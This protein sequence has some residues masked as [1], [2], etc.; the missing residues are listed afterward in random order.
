MYAHSQTPF[1]GTPSRESREKLTLPPLHRMYQSDGSEAS[2]HYPSAPYPFSSSPPP[3]SAMPSKAPA[4]MKAAPQSMPDER[5]IYYVDKQGH[6]TSPRRHKVDNY[7]PWF[8]RQ[9]ADLEMT[10]PQ[11][12]P[13]Q[14]ASADK[15]DASVDKLP[16]KRGRPPI[17]KLAITEE[18]PA[19]KKSKKTT[20]KQTTKKSDPI[21]AG[22]GKGSKGGKNAREPGGSDNEIQQLD[23][24]EARLAAITSTREFWTE[25][26]KL[27]IV[28]YIVAPE[29]WSNFKLNQARIFQEISM[30][31][32]KDRSAEKV[33]RQWQRLWD[34]YKA[35]RRHAHHTGGGDGDKNNESG[36]DEDDVKP[37]VKGEGAVKARK[38]KTCAQFSDA[39]LDVFE[40]SEIYTLID[41]VAHNQ[42]DVV[43]NFGLSSHRG[44]NDD[45]DNDGKMPPPPGRDPAMALLEETVKDLKHRQSEKVILEERRIALEEKR[46]EIQKKEADQKEQTYV[47]SLW[48]KY[49]ELLKSEDPLA[50]RLANKLGEKLAA[51]E[52]I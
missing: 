3:H 2:Y 25:E 44:D 20:K 40:A 28:S 46:L 18:Q 37:E 6:H 39:Q 51:I 11:Q 36:T 5:P 49:T 38:S 29:R 17:A 35:C 23:P 12:A 10:P 14:E 52:G 22:G 26:D 30:S 21:T 32:A 4:Y 9:Y 1:N 31:V 41:N 27:K 45:S 48:E 33:R 15:Q 24:E 19:A 43:P 8:A 16:A 50:K 7:D 13:Q 42:A 47:L 34:A